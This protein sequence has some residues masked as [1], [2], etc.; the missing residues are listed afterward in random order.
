MSLKSFVYTLAAV[1][2][3]ATSVQANPGEH[4][5]REHA[6]SPTHPAVDSAYIERR[7]IEYFHDIPVMIAIASCES[8]FRQ[9]DEDGLLLVNPNPNSTASG[10]FQILYTTHK[11]AWS[12]SNETHI[13]TLEGNLA[14][15]RKLYE[16]SGTTPWN[17]SRSC[18]QGRLARY[19]QR[20]ASLR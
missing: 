7:V 6:V 18:W 10:V 3:M 2:M 14:F 15:A 19:E 5:A 20:V 4:I 17:P 12:Q 9:Y 1:S 11:D 8:N 16:E 13:A